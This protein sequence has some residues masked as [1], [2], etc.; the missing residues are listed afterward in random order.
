MAEVRYGQDG[1]CEVSEGCEGGGRVWIGRI[2]G[3]DVGVEG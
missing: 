1:G 2:W 3:G